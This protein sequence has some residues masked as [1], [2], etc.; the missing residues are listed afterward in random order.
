MTSETVGRA[1]ALAPRFGIG[2]SPGKDHKTVLR[3]G[4]GLFYAGV[5][6]RAANFAGNPTRIVSAY[7]PTGQI[8]PKSPISLRERVCRER[9]WPSRVANPSRPELKRAQLC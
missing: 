3:A 7:D 4:T 9:R 5:P 1:A 8:E 6:L 2:Y